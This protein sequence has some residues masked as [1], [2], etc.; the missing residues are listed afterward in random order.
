MSKFGDTVKA[1]WRKA[2]PE[3][4]EGIDSTADEVLAKYEFN[5]RLRIIHLGAQISHESMGGSHLVE[6]LK[7]SAKRLIQVWPRRF[8]TLDS[9]K[10]Y[11]MNEEALADK[12]Y[13][14]RLGNHDPDDG[15]KYRGRGLIQLTGRA[16]FQTVQDRTGLQV[17]DDPEIASD[18]ETAL[19]VACFMFVKLGCMPYA[20]A[21]DVEAVTRKIN[22]GTT[23]LNERQDW[24]DRWDS[25]YPAD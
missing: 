21:D 11:A 15:Y 13:G 4:I 22:G 17:I 6:N 5:T 16:N 9:A 24:L 10:P 20:D 1:L 2:S 12:V 19:E 25:A 7:Y 23:G 3:L 8:P 18:P 14:G